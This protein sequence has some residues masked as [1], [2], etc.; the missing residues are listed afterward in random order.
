MHPR[1]A[2]FVQSSSSGK[3]AFN[4]VLPITA[5]SKFRSPP[6][7]LI[8]IYQLIPIVPV[9]PG[10]RVKLV[11]SFK[12]FLPPPVVPRFM[13]FRVQL[14]SPDPITPS[15]YQ[16]V[17]SRLSSKVEE[18]RG[19]DANNRSNYQRTNATQQPELA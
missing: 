5:S 11:S 10:A 1:E 17:K 13:A 2:K 3:F 15:F 4:F 6:R 9:S 18:R 12:R 19:F 16:R 7:L 14:H 8:P